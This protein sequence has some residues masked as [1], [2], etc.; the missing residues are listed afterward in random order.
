M[1][2]SRGL[3][4][5]IPAQRQRQNPGNYQKR[6]FEFVDPVLKQRPLKLARLQRGR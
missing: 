6:V 5:Y 3:L 4:C 2:H 1:V